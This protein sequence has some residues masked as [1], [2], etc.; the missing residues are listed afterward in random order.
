LLTEIAVRG[1]KLLPE[2]PLVTADPKSDTK[3]IERL[4]ANLEPLKG[5][6][7]EN[8]IF[9]NSV[10]FPDRKFT[11]PKPKNVLRIVALA[12]SFGV[13][14]MMPY[15]NNHLTQLETELE[16][17]AGSRKID[18]TNL[19]MVGNSPAHYLALLE[20][21]G[22]RLNPDLVLMYFF[23]GNDFVPFGSERAFAN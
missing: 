9:F 11:I 2:N 13:M 10:G 21:I 18:I 15:E 8:G 23:A 5:M 1:I 12:D 20:E 16:G 17:F 3:T 4:N 19:G 22:A 14:P 7:Y 6:Q